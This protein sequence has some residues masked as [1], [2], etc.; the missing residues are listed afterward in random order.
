MPGAFEVEEGGGV[1]G[2]G[3]D[4]GGRLVDGRR[5]RRS[6]DRVL[7]SVQGEGI[8][9]RVSGTGHGQCSSVERPAHT[10][11]PVVERPPPAD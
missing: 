6:P 2:R 7:P 10:R 8:E 11:L 4:E 9:M 3:E 1:V 5:A